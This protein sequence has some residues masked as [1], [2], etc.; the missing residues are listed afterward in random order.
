MNKR[1][2]SRQREHI[3]VAEEESLHEIG[4]HPRTRTRTLKDQGL[5]P[6]SSGTKIG[7]FTFDVSFYGFTHNCSLLSSIIVTL[8]ILSKIH[9]E[10]RRY[11]LM[12]QEIFVRV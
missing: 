4:N 3:L 8:Q 10:K 7:G 12:N 6:K 11:E 1:D 9:D 5:H 2:L